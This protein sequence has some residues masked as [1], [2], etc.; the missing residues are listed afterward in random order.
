MTGDISGLATPERDLWQSVLL[1]AVEDA[2]TGP[3]G[4]KGSAEYRTLQWQRARDYVTRPSKDLAE[5][6]GLAGVDM[7]AMIER[8]RVQIGSDTMSVQ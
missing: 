5:V 2:L 6:C 7:E 8:M 1:L 3:K 4:P